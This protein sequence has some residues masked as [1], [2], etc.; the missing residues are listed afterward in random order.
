MPT[1]FITG[2]SKEKADGTKSFTKESKA[3]TYQLLSI[4][5]EQQGKPGL[6][7]SLTGL[8]E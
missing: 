5:F 8:P 2:Q 4:A 6:P 7:K 3:L 1:K